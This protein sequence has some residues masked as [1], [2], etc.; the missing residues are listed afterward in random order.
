MSCSC[1]VHEKTCLLDNIR[2]VWTS[3]GEILESAGEATIVNWIVQEFAVRYGNFGACIVRGFG[4]VA[5]IHGSALN[6]VQ[7]VLSLRHKHALGGPSHMN[8]KKMRERSE[9]YHCKFRA[10][11]IND[12][13]E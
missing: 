6:Y 8:A 2:Y 3:D 10:Q 1:G 11:R 7:G 4:D 13:L 12:L 5:V 9:V